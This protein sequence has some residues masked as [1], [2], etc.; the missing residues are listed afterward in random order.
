MKR[1]CG[2]HVGRA[3]RHRRRFRAPARADRRSA[4]PCLRPALPVWRPPPG[5]LAAFPRRR[6]REGRKDVWVSHPF[7]ARCRSETGAPLSRAVCV[8]GY[9]RVSLASGQRCR[10]RPHATMQSDAQARERRPLVGTARRRRAAGKDPECPAGMK[11]WFGLTSAGPGVIG[12]G[13]ALPRVPTG[14]R[15]SLACGQHCRSGGPHRETWRR[16]L[17]GG[18]VR[19]ERMCGFRTPSGRDAGRR[20]A[21]RCRAPSARVAMRGFR[22]PPA[23]GASLGPRPPCRATRRQGNADLW[24]AQPAAGGRQR[25]TPSWRVVCLSAGPGVIGAGFAL[26]RVPGPTGRTARRSAFP[27]LRPALPVEAPTGRPGRLWRPPPG[28]LAAFLCYGRFVEAVRCRARKKDWQRTS[29]AAVDF[30]GKCER[31]LPPFT[32]NNDKSELAA[33][34]L[35]RARKFRFPARSAG[36]SLDG[37][38][39]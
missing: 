18:V 34:R 30:G 4:F 26:P 9:A 5:D 31:G 2:T 16:S 22:W 28:A 7:G 39:T 20:P 33:A 32:I 6:R 11:R 25:R 23:S 14:G 12:A 19:G 3:R 13:F 35:R 8:S 37:A 10:S 29:F 15:R 36:R 24:S 38:P 17:V 27:C 21:L 1:W